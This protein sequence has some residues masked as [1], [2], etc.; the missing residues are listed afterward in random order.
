MVVCQRINTGLIEYLLVKLSTGDVVKRVFKSGAII[1][2]LAIV[3]VGFYGVNYLQRLGPLPSG[4]VSHAICSGVFIAERDFDDVLSQDIAALQ[5]RM[6]RTEIEGNIVATRFGF[7]PFGYTSETLYRPGL[8]C[9]QLDGSAITDLEGPEYLERDLPQAPLPDNVWP[10]LVSDPEGVNS[11]MLDEALDRAFSDDAVNFEERQ[12]TRAIVIFHKGQLIAER[13]AEGFG[14]DIPLNSWSM[15]KSATGA[16]VGILVGKGKLNLADKSGLNGWN[17]PNDL[18]SKVT[19]EHLL[20]M[21]SGLEFNEGYEGDPISDVN[22]MLMKARDLPAFAAQYSVT[23]EPGI[24]WAYQTASP[25]LLGRIIRDS[26]TSE[27]AYHHFVQRELFNKLGMDNAHYQMDGGGTYVG[28]AMLYATARDWARFGLM[29]LNDGVVNGER[30][31]PAG[32]VEFSRTPTEASLKAR[33][34]A[35]QFWLNS[36]GAEQMMP[37]IPTDA[38]AARGHYGQSTFII[39]S[40]DLV[41]VRMGQS[42]T[43]DAWDMEGFLF[44]VLAALP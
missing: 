43:T 32:W 23:A 14:P 12:N 24:R 2:L 36:N 13:Y 18:R 28:G 4:F 3:G 39:P 8:G 21:T 9:A 25:V 5:R 44:S 26:F 35:A 27:E 40:R 30:I 10:D 37:S 16:L 29:Y 7:W 42:F 17:E 22:F 31:L 19:V 11:M 6:T 33:P 1:A 38:Y 34:Y 41:V 15:T 20:Q